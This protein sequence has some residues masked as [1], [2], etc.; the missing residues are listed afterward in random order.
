MNESRTEEQWKARIPRTYERLA[1]RVALEVQFRWSFDFNANPNAGVAELRPLNIE[2][3][4]SERV[5]ELRRLGNEA[6]EGNDATKALSLYEEAISMYK[7]KDELGAAVSKNAAAAALRLGKYDLAESRA[8]QAIEIEGPTITSLYR[9]AVARRKTVDF[10][11]AYEDLTA[12]MDL[13]PNE[14]L[15]R[16]EM[17]NLRR[18]FV[19]AQQNENDD[20]RVAALASL[21]PHGCEPEDLASA[22]DE[23][24]YASCPAGQTGWH[25]AFEA[26]VVE[27]RTLDGV[28][29]ISDV[30]P[31]PGVVLEDKATLRKAE[32]PPWQ[33]D[34]T[35]MASAGPYAGVPLTF[36]IIVARPGMPPKIRA[37][38]LL[39]HSLF[40]GGNHHA[41]RAV[42]D[43]YEHLLHGVTPSFSI[44]TCVAAIRDVLDAPPRTTSQQQQQQQPQ[45]QP[46]QF[47]GTV[48]TKSQVAW[49]RHAGA[50]AERRKVIDIFTTKHGHAMPDLYRLDAMEATLMKMVTQRTKDAIFI[51]KNPKMA[52][53]VI[54][55]GIFAFDLFD[56]AMATMFLAEIDAFYQSKLPAQR[57]N[58]MNAYGV[59]VNDIGLEPFI[60]LLQQVIF[61]PLARALFDDNDLGHPGT[62]FDSHHAFIVRYRRDEDSH[63]DIHTDDS[64]VTFNVS[65]GRG[66][67]KGSNLIFCGYLGQKNHR[68]HCVTYEHKLGKCCVHLGNRRHGTD[69]IAQGERVNLIVWCHSLAW[70]ESSGST[71]HN[72]HYEEEANPP[73]PRC[74]SYTHD[75][76]F[77]RYKPYPPGRE[78]FHGRGW[79]P[80]QGAEYP[81]FQRDDI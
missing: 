13:D 26:Q 22:V 16:Q 44:A 79:C 3:M 27:A 59:I 20:A 42:L 32:G 7:E 80:P 19:E 23:P 2:K 50:D 45:E 35:M 68:Q 25:S 73:D 43:F 58:S 40:T 49:K 15:V 30:T 55:P 57:P 5:E 76:D 63:L 70:R 17:M 72:R 48:A 33:V 65:L 6:L 9:R 37:I 14:A 69:D 46:F 78:Q 66:D 74:V 29:H 56:P 24:F 28:V 71:H 10:E 41:R 47:V 18:A 62:S 77:G 31:C 38:S 11:G 34:A 52:V 64:D 1:S 67:F 12:A 54:G 51:Q 4:S 60:T 8:T 75:R 39:S 53:D 36:R 21:L 61:V 81:G